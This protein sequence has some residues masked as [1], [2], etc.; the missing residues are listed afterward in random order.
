MV[1]K[2]ADASSKPEFFIIPIVSVRPDTIADFDLFLSMPGKAPVLYRAAKVP[3]TM[4]DLERL[5]AHKIEELHVLSSQQEEFRHYVEANLREIVS[6]ASLPTEYRS[7]LLYQ[8]AQG[9][10]KDV[11]EDPRAGNVM[12]R[13]EKMVENTV[14][15]LFSESNSFHHLLRVTSFDYY[16]YTHSVNVFVFFSAL[17]QKLGFSQE[18]IRRYGQGALLH[19]IGKSN[20][21]P[22]I[23]KA[24]GKLNDEQWKV[25]LQHP[26]YGHDV[27]CEQ[28]E[29]DPEILSIVR[30][31][32]EKLIG[33]GYPDG[34]SGDEITPWVRGA[35]IADIF[36]PKNGSCS[37]LF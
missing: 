25:M 2:N 9:L 23:I 37:L 3:F 19:D 12:E 8:S 36:D 35:T 13:T 31:H 5:K 17:F 29:E 24:K 18:E 33:N 11:L 34:L 28:G 15:L 26:V 4:E 27:L 10:V 20:M 22:A 7:K 30:H 1:Q 14:D 21:D 16:T 6:D 32:H